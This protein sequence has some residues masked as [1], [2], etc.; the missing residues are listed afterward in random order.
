[1]KKLLSK[2]LRGYTFLVLA[3]LLIS[4]VVLFPV[5]TNYYVLLAVLVIEFIVLLLVISYF[6]DK[7]INPVE[8]VA[9][10]M[11]KLLQ[12]NYNARV[13]QS[14]EG[15]IGEV[16]SKVNALARN[17]SE[18]TISEQIQAEQLTTVIENSESGLVLIDEK[19]YIHIV[20]RTFASMCGKRDQDY[21]GHLYYDGLE[22]EQLHHPVQEAFLY[23]KHVKHLCS[24]NTA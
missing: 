1:M 20:N 10:T 21:S 16:S 22:T 24:L 14:M 6:Y 19:G 7:Y 8:K 9:K 5:V 15:T 17:L 4:G 11:D 18:L 13:N 23:G 3:I 2:K 12:G